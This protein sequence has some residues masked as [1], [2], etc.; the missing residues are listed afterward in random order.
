M[1][2]ITEFYNTLMH[3]IIPITPFDKV[4][5]TLGTMSDIEKALGK[6]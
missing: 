2:D 1:N 5:G 4:S 6:H 3:K